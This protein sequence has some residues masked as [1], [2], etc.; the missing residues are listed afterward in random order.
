MTEEEKKNRLNNEE[1]FIDC[2]KHRHSI[3]D[4]IEKNPDGVDDATIAKVLNIS[5]EEVQKIYK[6]AIDKIK[7]SINR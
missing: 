6:S 5:V 4:I 2:A 1:D 3:K 7:L